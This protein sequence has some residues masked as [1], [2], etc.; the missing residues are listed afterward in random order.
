MKFKRINSLSDI[1]QVETKNGISNNF[2]DDHKNYCLTY[3]IL[4]DLLTFALKFGLL[5][6]K[7]IKSSIYLYF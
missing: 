1:G 4:T 5:S 7:Y 3:L 2:H 6:K